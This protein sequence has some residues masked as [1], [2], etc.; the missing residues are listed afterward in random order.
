MSNKRSMKSIAI[1]LLIIANV[2]IVIAL[3]ISIRN[4][5]NKIEVGKEIETQEV[6]EEFKETSQDENLEE[7]QI[8]ETQIN[9]EQEGK[10]TLKQIVGQ[11]NNENTSVVEI[12]LVL[13]G[14]A[15]FVLGLILIRV[16]KKIS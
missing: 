4:A 2:A 13:I 14:I 7:I 16:A 5:I 3:S 1:I 8:D 10:I 6:Q 15:L 9:E 12:V 11:L